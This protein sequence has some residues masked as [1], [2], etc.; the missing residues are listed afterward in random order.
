VHKRPIGVR[1]FVS[2]IAQECVVADALTKVVMAQGPRSERI[3]RRFD[4]TAY[5]HN[6]RYG[7]RT[8][9]SGA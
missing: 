3:L 1:S 4:A 6:A 9:G 5:Y 2:V 8:L 7:W